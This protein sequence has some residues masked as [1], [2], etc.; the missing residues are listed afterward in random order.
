MSKEQ[1]FQDSLI[2][3]RDKLAEII[4]IDFEELHGPKWMNCNEVYDARPKGFEKSKMNDLKTWDLTQLLTLLWSKAMKFNENK[5]GKKSHITFIKAIKAYRNEWAHQQPLD[6]FE[7]YRAIDL[8]ILVL[9]LLGHWSEE[10]KKNRILLAKEIA[11]LD[12]QAEEEKSNAKVKE[13]KNKGKFDEEKKNEKES[14]WKLE[15]EKKKSKSDTLEGIEESKNQDS[16]KITPKEPKHPDDMDIEIPNVTVRKTD[17][18][19]NEKVAINIEQAEI[20][21]KKE[22]NK[23]AAVNVTQVP[24]HLAQTTLNFPKLPAQKEDSKKT[25]NQ[26]GNPASFKLPNDSIQFPDFSSPSSVNL[27]NDSLQI[28]TKSRYNDS[29]PNDN[30]QAQPLRKSEVKLKI[31]PQEN[32]NKPNFFPSKNEYDAPLQAEENQIDRNKLPKFYTYNVNQAFKAENSRPDIYA[33]SIQENPIAPQPSKFDNP[34]PNFYAGN[35]QINPINPQPPRLDNPQSNLYAVNNQI[36]PI[37][38]QPRLDNPQ[39]NFYAV[40]K[41]INPINLQKGDEIVNVIPRPFLPNM[42]SQV[43]AFNSQAQVLNQ[44]QVPFNSS[45]PTYQNQ[46]QKVSNSSY[47]PVSYEFHSQAPQRPNLNPQPSFIPME[48]S[49]STYQNLPPQP[50][51]YELPSQSLQIPSFYSKPPPLT[52]LENTKNPYSNPSQNVSQSINIDSYLPWCINCT[53]IITEELY[54]E[55]SSKCKKNIC[56]NC[57]SKFASKVKKPLTIC[58]S[59]KQSL[60]Q[61]EMDYLDYIA[62]QKN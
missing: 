45:V 25:T 5:F 17:K 20:I 55:H 43:P 37:N 4:S 57:I 38:P 3:F 13:N 26:F 22:P 15:E 7:I 10:L 28:P 48:N 40:N 18:E 27:P 16:I 53:N 30:I 19:A 24:D 6:L 52:P 49:K 2:A 54:F 51:R 12:S 39:S 58:P 59:C 33:G 61:S 34:L 60:S 44:S 46:S 21:G 47:Q 8:M 11:K 9:E 35:N 62:S 50:A 32:I 1:I 31:P 36:N 29:G 14:R 41:P 23:E 56:W 42:N